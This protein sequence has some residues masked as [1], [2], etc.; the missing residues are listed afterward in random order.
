M[1]SRRLTSVLAV[2]GLIGG[3]L[4]AQPQPAFAMGEGGIRGE[5][6]QQFGG[7]KDQFSVDSPF[8]ATSFNASDSASFDEA[9]VSADQHF[10]ETVI[11]SD[12]EQ[13]DVDGSVSAAVGTGDLSAGGNSDYSVNF[14][15]EDL[16]FTLTGSMSVAS[17]GQPGD[18]AIAEVH[19][20][21]DSGDVVHIRIAAGDGN[22][23][24]SVSETGTLPAGGQ[25]TVTANVFIGS[26]PA[27]TTASAEF[28]L[29]LTLTPGSCTQPGPR[30]GR[31]GAACAPTDHI[32]FNTPGVSGQRLAVLDAEGAN[33]S[34]PLLL[35]GASQD[36]QSPAWATVGGRVAVVSNGEIFVVTAGGSDLEQQLT[37]TTGINDL[38]A[39]S[40]N[41][42]SI[43]FVSTRDGNAERSEERRVGKECR[44]R[45]S[46]Y[47]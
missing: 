36:L 40:P 35:A 47:H 3:V 38:P 5:V 15:G 1:T 13:V 9:G 20:T 39:W 23:S 17:E 37:N 33:P 34:T 7:T 46:P 10:D 45:W 31:A 14:G 32:L 29:T 4:I 11:G 12:L 41:G 8:G 28:D 21:D 26:T 2:A 27:D 43:A 30:S 6:D 18:A 22:D 24:D 25:L 44:S 16:A 42:G 19:L